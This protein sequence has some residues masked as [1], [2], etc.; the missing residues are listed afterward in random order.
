MTEK[1]LLFLQPNSIP[2][3]QTPDDERPHNDYEYIGGDGADEQSAAVRFE[4]YIPERH[5]ELIHYC[6]LGGE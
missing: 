3:P 5:G 1:W 4:C 6:G 2:R